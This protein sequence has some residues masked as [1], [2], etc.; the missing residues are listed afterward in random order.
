MISDS[1]LDDAFLGNQLD[2]EQLKTDSNPVGYIPG[3]GAAFILLGSTNET[4]GIPIEMSVF[5][6]NST[7]ESDADN[8]SKHWLSD[9][10]ANLVKNSVGV[11]NDKTV[12]P[13][14]VTDINGEELRAMEFGMLHVKLKAAYPTALFLPEE[15]PALSF[16]ETGIMAGSLAFLTTLASIERRYARHNEFLILLSENS[17]QRAVI[18]MKFYS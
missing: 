14:C 13:Q 6:E 9:K 4:A 17:G 1:L 10:L 5:L 11:R 18:Y 3:E 7:I 8:Y 2:N 16:A 12:F 15:V